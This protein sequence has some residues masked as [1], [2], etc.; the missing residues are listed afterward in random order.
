MA[1]AAAGIQR[2]CTEEL[3]KLLAEMKQ[4]ITLVGQRFLCALKR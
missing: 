2:L 3:S 4:L 1:C